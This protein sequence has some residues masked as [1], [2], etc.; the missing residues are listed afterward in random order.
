MNRRRIFSFSA[1]VVCAFAFSCVSRHIEN[2]PTGSPKAN[3]DRHWAH[4]ERLRTLMADLDRA[5]RTDWPQE[6]QGEV[7][8]TGPSRDTCLSEAADH[9]MA[10][11]EAAKKLPEATLRL[12]LSEVDRRS[13]NAQAETLYDQAKRLEQTARTGDVGGM[14]TALVEIDATCRSC[15]TRFRDV[16]GPLGR[17]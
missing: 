4:D 15:H 3:A 17:E 10:L 14:Q 16:S 13:F 5:S 7:K 2:G 12:R 8:L 1:I 6:L 9:A 11:A